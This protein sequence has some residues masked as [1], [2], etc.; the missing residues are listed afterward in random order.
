MLQAYFETAWHTGP[1]PRL[2]FAAVG[3]A[4]GSLLFVGFIARWLSAGY[5]DGACG[6]QFRLPLK[7]LPLLLLSPWLYVSLVGTF[8]ALFVADLL[9]GERSGPIRRLDAWVLSRHEAGLP[10]FV[11]P[12]L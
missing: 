5:L 3:M 12:F 4:W 1:A 10:A 9:A 8:E 11:A 7:A 2:A 6:R